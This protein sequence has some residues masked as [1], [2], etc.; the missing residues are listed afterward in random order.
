MPHSAY[1]RPVPG[2]KMAV[3]MVHGIVGTPRHFD[4]LLE[5]IPEDVTVM[6]I[7][8]EGHGGT[9][10]DF[11]RASMKG[12][13]AQVESAL[14]QLC[15]THERV[16]VVAHSMGTLLTA[17]AVQTQPKVKGML[18]LN[19]PLRVWVAPK[20]VPTSLRWCFGWLRPDHPTDQGLKAAASASPD[21]RLWR[22]LAWLPR[23]W[24][25]LVLCRESRRRFET[26]TQSVCAFQSREDE[27]VRRSSSRHLLKNS[28]IVC[29]EL[30]DCGHFA[31][32][33]EAQD[34]IR[35]CLKQML[36]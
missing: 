23:F 30:P 20:L 10:K 34:R 5:V 3:L 8:L 13:K 21:P 22:Y 6:N 1:I 17:R 32:T 14:E 28:A 31:Y 11:G 25:L 18:Y 15:R 24:E 36:Q 9:V 35:A 26:M 16:V 33:P 12:W 7:L 29:H 19:V 2:A 4:F 27:L